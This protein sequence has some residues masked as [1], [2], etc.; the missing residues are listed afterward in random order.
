[1]DDL[2]RETGYDIRTVEK[3]IEEIVEDEAEWW[4]DGSA[5]LL[6]CDKKLQRQW[7]QRRSTH[8]VN[9]RLLLRLRGVMQRPEF[10]LVLAFLIGGGK[11]VTDEIGYGKAVRRRVYHC[12]LSLS[13]KEIARRLEMSERAVKRHLRNAKALGLFS[14]R[15][16]RCDR[17]RIIR[18]ATP[19]FGIVEARFFSKFAK[20]LAAKKLAARPVTPVPKVRERRCRNGPGRST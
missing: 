3:G 20:K 5:G 16:M 19:V 18:R 10:N 2:V 11:A 1:M 6:V 13:V 9:Y 15:P 12:P 8:R 17:R 7:R 14:A 4:D